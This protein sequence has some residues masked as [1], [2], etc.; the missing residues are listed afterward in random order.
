VPRK[1]TD[2]AADAPP[3]R[4]DRPA[5]ERYPQ[6]TFRKYVQL[7]LLPRSRRVGRKGKHRGS[8]GLYPTA[9]LGRVVEIRGLMEQGFT[10]EE[11]QRSSVVVGQ[12]VEVLRRS[13][14][15]LFD[16]LDVELER[17]PAMKTP[18]ALKRL[19][20]LR[21]Q[22][23]TLADALEA[24]TRELLPPVVT[25]HEP[26]DPLAVA[27]EIVREGDKARRIAAKPTARPT[28][29]TPARPG[30]TRA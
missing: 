23:D 4:G 8:H 15:A 29:K 16:R 25:P 20:G 1:A 6:A 2:E 19:A 14:A 30:P 21:V 12:E 18:A 10:L 17:R 7:G 3:R 11:I 5:V 28:P 22:A 24:A 9:C 13:A 26:E 27:R